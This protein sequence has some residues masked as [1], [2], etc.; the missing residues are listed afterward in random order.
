MPLILGELTRS[1]LEQI[2][3]KPSKKEMKKLLGTH[4]TIIRIQ[5][6]CN[7]FPNGGT[8][9]QAMWAEIVFQK[10]DDYVEDL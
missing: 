4:G 2:N 3:G 1:N 9:K 10:E 5:G 8:P 6:E 7:S